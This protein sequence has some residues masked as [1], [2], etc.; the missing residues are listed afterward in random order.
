[1]IKFFKN[2][3]YRVTREIIYRRRLKQNRKK[4]PFI[5]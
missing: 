2:L 3:Y 4:D 5:Y 1:M